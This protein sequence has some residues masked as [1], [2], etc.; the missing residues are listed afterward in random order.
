MKLRFIVHELYCHFDSKFHNTDPRLSKPIDNQSIT[1]FLI[2]VHKDYNLNSINN[3]FLFKYFIYQYDYWKSKE[4]R[5]F[6]NHTRLINIIGPKA[7]SRFKQIQTNSTYN[8]YNAEKSLVEY[9]IDRSIL[10]RYNH[11]KSSDPSKLH[12]DEEKEK[13]VF[14]SNHH[15]QL[16]HC[17]DNT[18]LYNHNSNHCQV[19][20]MQNVCKRMLKDNLPQLYVNRGYEL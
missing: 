2:E 17:I 12:I 5:A 13:I 10:S 20:T 8:W 16:A 19:C 9:G 3:D 11:N 15:L 6:G 7:Y 18:T 14:K 4:I 1:N